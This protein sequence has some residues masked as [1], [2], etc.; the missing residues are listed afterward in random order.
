MYWALIKLIMG[1]YSMVMMFFGNEVSSVK[2]LRLFL[3]TL[4]DMV[5]HRTMD[6]GWQVSFYASLHLRL[7][8]CD[9]FA[10]AKLRFLDSMGITHVNFKTSVSFIITKNAILQTTQVLVPY[11]NG[12]IFKYLI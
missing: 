11:I 6:L 4:I 9:V 1:M 12:A 7:R 5:S 2:N 10:S 3:H 8:Y